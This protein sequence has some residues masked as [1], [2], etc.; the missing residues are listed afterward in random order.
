MKPIKSFVPVAQWLMRITV[1]LILFNLYF[2]RIDD[3]NFTSV[4][5]LVSVLLVIFSALLVIGGFLKKHS[6]TVVSGLVISIL[7]LIMILIAGVDFDAVTTH[8]AQFSI[9]LYFMARGNRN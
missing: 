9:G 5:W 4:E 7:S 6:T 1:A 2:H 8:I 3:L